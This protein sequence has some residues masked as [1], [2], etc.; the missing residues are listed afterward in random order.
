[1][2]DMNLEVHIIPVHDPDRAKQFYQRLGWRLDN[3][4]SPA[5][6]VRL[7]QFT[8]PGSG[9][10]VTFG[11]GL[12]TA[13]ALGPP[14]VPDA[15]DRDQGPHRTASPGTFQGGLIVTDILAAHRDLTDRGIEVGEVFHGFPVPEEA[16]MPG[17]HPERESR[18]SF[19]PFQDSEGNAW[20]VQE[21]TT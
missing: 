15:A 2:V 7:I 3:D 20:L 6:G 4:A 1:M 13:F 16:R 21:I 5:D 11:T 19:F 17:P 9:C 18:A 8:P 10:S 12:T 14:T